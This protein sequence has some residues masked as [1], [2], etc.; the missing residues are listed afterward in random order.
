LGK[1]DM[2]FLRPGSS[3]LERIQGA[4]LSDE[5][6]VTMVEHLKKSSAA[7]YDS[8]A[9]EWIDEE[10]QR[11]ASSPG[12]DGSPE[13]SGHTDP[14]WNE[15]LGL[16]QRQGA[17]SASYLQR[18]MKIGYNR[19]ARIVEAMESQGLVAKADGSKPR[20]WIGH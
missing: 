10:Y 5:E 18:M 11:Q 15:A 20:A 13:T 7:H 16:A 9:M 2:L 6:V 3:K 12:L 8:S 1:G 14:K 19:A 17:I 4:F